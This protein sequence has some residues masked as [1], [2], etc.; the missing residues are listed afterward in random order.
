[1]EKCTCGSGYYP[2]PLYDGHGIYLC[3]ACMSC[4]DSKLSKYRSDIMSDY[5]CDEQI[6]PD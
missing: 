3:L 6:E 1:M 4:E 2:Y 5:D